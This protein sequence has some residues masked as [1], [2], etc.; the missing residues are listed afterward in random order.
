M[1]PAACDLLDVARLKAEQVAKLL[2]KLPPGTLGDD[3]EECRQAAAN[4]W[5]VLD[6]R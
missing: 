5:A 3:Q 6:R 1:T 2:A 4:I